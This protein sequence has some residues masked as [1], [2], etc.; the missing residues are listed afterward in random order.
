ML[1]YI[2]PSMPSILTL[3][4][5]MFSGGDAQLS[6]RGIR[7]DI[8]AYIACQIICMIYMHILTLASIRISRH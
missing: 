7:D 3:C 4:S 2:K 6:N 1:K 8:I 5:Y